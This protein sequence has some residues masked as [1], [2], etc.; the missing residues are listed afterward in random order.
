MEPVRDLHGAGPGCPECH[1]LELAGVPKRHHEVGV[2]DRPPEN[3]ERAEAQRLRAHLGVSRIGDDH[4]GDPLP[5]PGQAPERAQRP[6]AKGEIEHQSP[7]ARPVER[8]R[9]G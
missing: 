3:V 4:G 5:A 1:I 2:T 6:R 9:Q 7:R 8:R